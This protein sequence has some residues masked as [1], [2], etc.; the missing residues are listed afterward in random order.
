MEKK[1]LWPWLKRE[2]FRVLK[3]LFY[4]H[5]NL[6]GLWHRIMAS[7]PLG[8]QGLPCDQLCGAAIYLKVGKR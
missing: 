3:P 2:D 1:R 4:N 5:I 6:Y 7:D 8:Q